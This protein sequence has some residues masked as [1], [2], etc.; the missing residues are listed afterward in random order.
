MALRPKLFASLKGKHRDEGSGLEL[1]T[2]TKGETKSE[3][4]HFVRDDKKD[5]RE[6][7]KAVRVT[8]PFV[9]LRSA[10][11]K[12]LVLMIEPRRKARRK[13]RSLTS[14]GMTKK[15]FGMTKKTGRVT[16][17]FVTLRSA[18]TKGLAL[19]IEPRRN[20][21]R[22]ARSL[23]SFGMTKKTVGV[24]FPFVTLR[25]EPRRNERRKARSL[26]S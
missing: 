4:P 7:K 2:K 10:A 17:P 12:G 3:I 26:T 1:R 8:F 15:T 11:T 13:A 5:V 18:A 19:R 25:I 22:K 21:R 23:T 9:T 24:T 20:E 14:F 6:E 16:F